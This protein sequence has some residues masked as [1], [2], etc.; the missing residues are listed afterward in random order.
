MQNFKNKVV[1]ITGAAGGI[2]RAMAEAFLREGSKV[3]IADIDADS[4]V[5]TRRELLSVSPEVEAVVTDVSKPEQV[6]H[7]AAEA[8]R[9]FGR[10]D[11][12]CNNAAITYGGPATWESTIDDWQRVLGVNLMGVVHGLRSFVP[13]ILCQ[14]GE[15]VIVNTSSILGLQLGS[16][17][18]VYP[19]SKHGVV[20]LSE[21]IYNEFDR[22]KIP[23]SVHVLCPSF[24]ATNILASSHNGSST[25]SRP[26]EPPPSL[27]AEKY[28]R[29]FQKQHRDGMPPEEVATMTLD[30]IRS[31][32]FYIVTHPKMKALVE[33]R[34]KA[35]LEGAT[36]SDT[37]YLRENATNLGMT[38]PPPYPDEV[39]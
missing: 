25:D 35:I 22:R 26:G 34:M 32:E 15:G 18:A 17:N 13:R 28:F 3:V 30:A 39:L 31:G 7:L 27:Q 20:V 6:E 16:T 9:I 38:P 21:S 10:V 12:L 36:P 4:L 33:C 14:G 5:A 2:G 37:E 24:V 19:V 23:I 11:I 29:W 8:Y 1:V